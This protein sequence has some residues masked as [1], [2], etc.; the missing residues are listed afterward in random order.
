MKK[1]FI[2][3]AML[4]ITAGAMAQLKINHVG[5]V[6]I[7]AQTV[8]WEAGLRVTV[9]TK[10]SCAYNFC[11]QY[12]NKD[13]FFVCA[14]GYLWSL[15]APY[16]GSD[17]A[18]KKN[19][20]PIEGALRKITTLQGVRYQYNEGREEE[21]GDT[22]NLINNEDFRLGFIAQ[23]VERVFPE[24]IKDMPDGMKAMS[25]TDL[26]AVLVEAIKEQQVQ[27]DSIGNSLYLALK[28]INKQQTLIES[29][30][31]M[32]YEQGTDIVFL[33]EQIG[34]LSKRIDFLTEQINKCCED[35]GKLLAPPQQTPPI[36]GS[37]NQGESQNNNSAKN[38]NSMQNTEKAR[39]FQNV[40][41]PFSANTEIRFEVPEKST[42]AKLLIHDM[43]GAEIKSYTITSK[44]AGNIVIQAQ[45]LQAGM[46]MYT[47]LVNNTIID[48][49][50]MILTK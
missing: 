36:D 35:G 50:K 18:L 48:T 28:T 14:E 49:K 16:I 46:Y 12:L 6:D 26:I 3:M 17:I 10:S 4:A 44:G 22:L 7:K 25:Y 20:T 23:D 37:N 19:I 42:S 8:N 47:L 45:E 38:E 5:M 40:P 2:L 13:V 30:Q 9:P 34:F 29:L 33:N 32:V 39:L 41:N 43:Q 15:K 24:V 31:R 21:E 11:S 27:I 1:F